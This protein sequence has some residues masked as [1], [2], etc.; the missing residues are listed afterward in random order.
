LVTPDKFFEDDTTTNKNTPDNAQTSDNSNTSTNQPVQYHPNN[1]RP[2][3]R[4]RSKQ[5]KEEELRNTDEAIVKRQE[6]AEKEHNRQDSIATP[7]GLFETDHANTEEA[8]RIREERAKKA[9][10]E[11]IALP[12]GFLTAQDPGDNEDDASREK[13]R[14]HQRKQSLMKAVGDKGHLSDEDTEKTQHVDYEARRIL[15][16]NSRMKKEPAIAEDGDPNKVTHKRE[17]SVHLPEPKAEDRLKFEDPAVLLMAEE[18]VRM[19]K[20]KL[21]KIEEEKKTVE[22]QLQDDKQEAK[23]REQKLVH[24]TELR[25]EEKFQKEKTVLA[26]N[27]KKEIDQ[28]TIRMDDLKNQLNQAA[29]SKLKL[30][31]CTNNEINC[32]NRVINALLQSEK[33]KEITRLLLEDCRNQS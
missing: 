5:L 30:I 13:R 26:A 4:R 14:K 22:I 18:E 17:A 15:D 23:Q 21:N 9:R 10:K 6:R 1:D 12:K 7:S 33:C 3:K 25:I 31:Q 16:R 19:L 20:E 32:L 11:S 29:N 2:N 28:M 8:K 24:Q 27:G